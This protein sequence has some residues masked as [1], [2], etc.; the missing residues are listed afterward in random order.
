MAGG[1]INR[2]RGG[3]AK[4]EGLKVG[5]WEGGK[6]SGLLRRDALGGFELCLGAVSP[7]LGSDWRFQKGRSDVGRLRPGELMSIQ[8]EMLSKERGVG[9]GA[10][11]GEKTGPKDQGD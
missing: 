7:R 8:N 10:G 11:D 9:S 5:K 4:W 3:V 1:E 2:K 6:R